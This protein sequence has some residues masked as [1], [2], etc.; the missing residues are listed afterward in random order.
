[1]KKH[2]KHNI[3]YILTRQKVFCFVGFSATVAVVSACVPSGLSF[4]S[5]QFVMYTLENK[6]KYK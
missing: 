2:E 5:M 3:R 4:S 1:M 6:A